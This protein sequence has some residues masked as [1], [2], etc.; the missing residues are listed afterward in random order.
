[1][2]LLDLKK[3]IRDG[4]EVN[5][6]DYAQ[7]FQTNLFEVFSAIKK[8]DEDV[9]LNTIAFQNHNPGVDV[10]KIELNVFYYFC[11]NDFE[12]AVAMK[13]FCVEK[14]S[15]DKLLS[16]FKN[17]KILKQVEINLLTPQNEKITLFT[18]S[19]VFKT[20]FVT[21]NKISHPFFEKFEELED[22]LWQ[23]VSKNCDKLQE[24]YQNEI[25]FEIK[26]RKNVLSMLK[27]DKKRLMFDISIEQELIRL[28]PQDK[29]LRQRLKQKFEN[30]LKEKKEYETQEKQILKGLNMSIKTFKTKDAK[31][32]LGLIFGRKA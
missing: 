17:E 32:D 15:L 30:E 11:K 29:V 5:L 8:K 20:I 4:K 22:C 16:E 12:K 2:N 24:R 9:V 28:N 27:E 13:K 31:E 10:G 23:V 7:I 25:I 1:M 18:K 19:K 6:T 14:T 3:Q 26:N 21:Q